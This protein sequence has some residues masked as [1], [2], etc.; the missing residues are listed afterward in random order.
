MNESIEKLNS[1][2]ISLHFILDMARTNRHNRMTTGGSSYLKQP[3]AIMLDKNGRVLDREKNRHDRIRELKAE[4]KR[5]QKK[6][7]EAQNMFDEAMDI[8]ANVE[9]MFLDLET[10]FPDLK[11]P[12]N[13]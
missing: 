3:P 8:M 1:I 10:Y 13:K 2:E 12:E 4:F 6:M 7:D 11:G 9:K 5:A